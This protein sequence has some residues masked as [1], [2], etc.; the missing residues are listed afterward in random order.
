MKPRS[1]GRFAPRSWQLVML[2][3]LLLLLSACKSADSSN[4]TSK[5][6]DAP[7][8]TYTAAIYIEAA[9]TARL[10]LYFGERA[11][12]EF[13]ANAGEERVHSY[14]W[15]NRWGGTMTGDYRG[16]G[17]WLINVQP[18]W[19]PS[20]SGEEQWWLFEAGDKPPQL[21]RQAK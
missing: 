15:A 1:R 3:G 18:N 12:G 6:A 19:G 16:R 4:L 7:R 9:A 10:R 21:K 5:Q 14:I 20:K 17:I 2:S 8:P 13:E 11:S